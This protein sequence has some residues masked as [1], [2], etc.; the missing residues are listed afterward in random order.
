MKYYFFEVKEKKLS[1]CLASNFLF[2]EFNI[3]NIV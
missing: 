1:L 2:H 3:L